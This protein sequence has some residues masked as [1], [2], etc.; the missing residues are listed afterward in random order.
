MSVRQT[1]DVRHP[2]LPFRAIWGVGEGG[3]RRK[4]TAR[5]HTLKKYDELV[6]GL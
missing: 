5:M 6:T 1:G 2:R 3:G 4:V